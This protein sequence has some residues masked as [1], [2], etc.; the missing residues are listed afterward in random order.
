[1]QNIY[2]QCCS[3]SGIIFK[4]LFAVMI[5]IIVSHYYCLLVFPKHDVTELKC[6]LPEI[7][8]ELRGRSA[9]HRA[10][11]SRMPGSLGHVSGTW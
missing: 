1:M 4:C 11:L 2:K 8:Q 5:T 6:G 9:I 3:I 7:R 10:T